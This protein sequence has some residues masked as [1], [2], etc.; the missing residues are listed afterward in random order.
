[1]YADKLVSL[2]CLILGLAL[3]VYSAD[4]TC[5]NGVQQSP[6]NIEIEDSK[7]SKKLMYET[8]VPQ[9][10][11]FKVTMSNNTLRYELVYVLGYAFPHINWL[12]ISQSS[13]NW[14][15]NHFEFHWTSNDTKGSEHS[16]DRTFGA[17]EL[18]FYYINPTADSLETAQKETN[19]VL[20]QVI[21]LR[22][23]NKLDLADMLKLNFTDKIENAQIDVSLSNFISLKENA[24]FFKYE[25]S[26]ASS[27][28]VKMQ[29]LIMAEWLEVTE[30]QLRMLRSLSN[31]GN[32]RDQY[33]LTKDSIVL[34]NFEVHTPV[35]FDNTVLMYHC[36]TV[37]S[38]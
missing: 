11:P 25:G 5:I 16:I 7:Y 6:V 34:R 22:L 36:N 29:W 26:I 14:D 3:T 23:G 9:T 19:G 21:I 15:F 38:R 32:A 20:V 13:Q 8:T 12:R 37:G 30:E 2:H 10:S 18:Q 4:V 1:M 24:K 27:P 31:D 33:E 28:C 17:A 35:K